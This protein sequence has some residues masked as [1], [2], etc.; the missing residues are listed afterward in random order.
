[1]ILKESF[2]SQGKVNIPTPFT[3]ASDK[4][5]SFFLR[6]PLLGSSSVASSKSLV[7]DDAYIH[8]YILTLKGQFTHQTYGLN[9]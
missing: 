2:G 7:T 8:M 3:D 1:M 6:A 5:A 4:S 9:R